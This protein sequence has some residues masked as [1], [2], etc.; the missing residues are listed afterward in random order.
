[1][2]PSTNLQ[3]C[4]AYCRV[5]RA[6]QKL[7]GHGIVG[8]ATTA[9]EYAQRRG[10]QFVRVFEDDITGKVLKRPG[11]DDMLTFLRKQK[12]PYVVI[13]YDLARLARDLYVHLALRKA[14]AEAGGVLESPT[15]EIGDDP[16]RELSENIQASFN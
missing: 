14:I 11:M 4:I 9:R 12:E 10:Y 2:K 13:I 5:S 7:N 16:E 6:D 3:K 8:Q 1:M 15:L